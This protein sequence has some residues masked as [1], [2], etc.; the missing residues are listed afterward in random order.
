MFL[1]L[2]S[3]DTMTKLER[4]EKRRQFVLW[5]ISMQRELKLRQRSV[6]LAETDV[7]ISIGVFLVTVDDLFAGECIV[8]LKRVVRSESY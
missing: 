5:D 2:F 1:S 8:L 3:I 6:A 7:D 4:P